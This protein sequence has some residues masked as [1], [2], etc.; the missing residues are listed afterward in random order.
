MIE[1]KVENTIE[2][3]MDLKLVKEKTIQ[4]PLSFSISSILG[5]TDQKKT[6]DAEIPRVPAAYYST[7]HHYGHPES[8]NYQHFGKFS[9]FTVNFDNVIF[10]KWLYS[11]C[12]VL[13]KYRLFWN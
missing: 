2:T 4:K 1:V 13:K 5:E 12:Y 7:I 3:K 11:F 9:K 8:T 6:E 10:I